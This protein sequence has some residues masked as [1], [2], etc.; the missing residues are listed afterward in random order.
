[1]LQ[2]KQILSFLPA[3]GLVSNLP[4]IRNWGCSWFCPRLFLFFFFLHWYGTVHRFTCQL[5]KAGMTFSNNWPPVFTLAFCSWLGALKITLRATFNLFLWNGNRTVSDTEVNG[6]VWGHWGIDLGTFRLG[7][8]KCHS[9]FLSMF[10]WE[11]SMPW[12]K[13]M[14]HMHRSTEK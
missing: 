3:A 12:G 4:R 8:W 11:E 7:G 5:M 13:H 6:H 9:L 1:M 10:Q 2:P 14:D